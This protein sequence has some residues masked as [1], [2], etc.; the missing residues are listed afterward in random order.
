MPKLTLE[1]WLAYGI[2]H[3]FCSE[4]VCSTHDGI[5]YTPEEE[6]EWEAGSD[7]CA[8]VVRIDA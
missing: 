2:E 6:S 5:P 3:G 7:P 8:F 4:V 1:E